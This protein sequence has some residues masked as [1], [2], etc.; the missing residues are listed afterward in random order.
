MPLLI[1]TAARVSDEVPTMQII[2]IAVVVVI[3][4]VLLLGMV[5]PTVG[6]Q[7]RVRKINAAIEY[8]NDSG[9]RAGRLR[10]SVCDAEISAR[11]AA[12]LPGVFER[13][14]LGLRSGSLCS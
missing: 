9:W 12:S 6:A 3:L 14:L 1:L 7:I 2:C 5:R 13:P 11:C 4:S 10:S 8:C